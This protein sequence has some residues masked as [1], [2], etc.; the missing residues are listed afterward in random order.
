MIISQTGKISEGFYALGHPFIPIYLLDGPAPAIFDAGLAFLADLYVSEIKKRLGDRQPAYCFITHMHFDH[1]GSA[2]A[3]KENFP[4]MRIVAS[5]QSAGI[6][7]NPKAIQL[8]DQLNQAAERSVADFGIEHSYNG[9]FEPFTVDRHIS[10]D[11]TIELAASQH[12]RAVETPGHTRDCVSYLIEEKNILLS[13][14]ALG[15]EHRKGVI[16]TDCLSD[17]DAYRTSLLKLV[18]LEPDVVCPGHFFVYTGRDAKRYTENA[19]KACRQFRTLVETLHR[20]ENGD[21]QQVMQ[22]IKSIEYDNSAVPRQPE[23][24]YMI[25]LEARIKAVLGG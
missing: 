9:R 20:E 11:E 12:V 19:A 8:I 6:L 16:V 18:R 25:N 24:A 4:R 10:D 15:Q 13:S 14:E 1:C 7:N 5:R 2:A 23:I 21:R 17:Y 22:R 3:L